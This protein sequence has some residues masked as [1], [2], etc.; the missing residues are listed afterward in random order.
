ME[1]YLHHLSNKPWEFVFVDISRKLGN[2]LHFIY[3]EVGGPVE[4]TFSIN[5]P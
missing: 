5:T 1:V 4:F 3:L 2:N